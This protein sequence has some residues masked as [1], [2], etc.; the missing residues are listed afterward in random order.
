M[1]DDRDDTLQFDSVVPPPLPVGAAAAPTDV[2]CASENRASAPTYFG[3]ALA[4]SASAA[5]FSSKRAPARM[6]E[7]P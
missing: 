4:A 6:F 7:R 1:S 5:R 3:V 2:I